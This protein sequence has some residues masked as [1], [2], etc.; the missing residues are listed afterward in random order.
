VR[1]PEKADKKE[2]KKDDAQRSLPFG[3]PGRCEVRAVAAV[4]IALLLGGCGNLP[5]IDD[6]HTPRPV[7]IDIAIDAS[8][9]STGSPETLRETLGV[10]SR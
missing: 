6:D 3:S 10:S 2:Q 7:T 5:F 1:K 4:A 9:G 8:E